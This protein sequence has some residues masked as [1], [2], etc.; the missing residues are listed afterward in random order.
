MITR[1]FL[2]TAWN[3]NPALLLVCLAAF[4]GYLAK[5]GFAKRAWFFA[6][7]IAVVLLTLCSPLNALADGYLFSAHMTQHILLLLIAPA[8]LVRSLPADFA[9]RGFLKKLANPLLGL[10]CGVGAMWLWHAPA[11]C[12][13]AAT[14]R[15]VYAMQAV[16]LLAAGSAFWWQILAPDERQRL[17]P[18]AA[19]VYLFAACTGCS[20]LGIIITFSPVS[21]CSAY[22]NPTDKLGLLDTLRSGWG[23]TPTRDQQIGGLLM[24]VPMCMVYVS[25]ILAQFARWYGASANTSIS[26]TGT[27]KN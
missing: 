21:V 9:L 12:N 17:S 8:L 19:V 4:A 2:I 23:M 5:F 1:E 10:L 24:W 13:A 18:L 22:V 14:S 27:A 15:P 20:V 25:A 26:A 3:W 16:S 7:A 6:A 11:L